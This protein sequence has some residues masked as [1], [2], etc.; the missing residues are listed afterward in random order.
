MGPSEKSQYEMTAF[1]EYEEKIKTLEG[2][3]VEQKKNFEYIID[4]K[5]EALASLEF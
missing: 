5:N 3:I 1:K 2:K 4:S